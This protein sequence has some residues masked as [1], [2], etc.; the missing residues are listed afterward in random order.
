M[1]ADILRNVNS[2]II[3]RWDDFMHVLQEHYHLSKENS[4]YISTITDYLEVQN[5]I[6]IT[7]NLDV[8][9]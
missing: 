9:R 4:D 1:N 5:H 2:P 6:F 3:K 8:S 7:Y